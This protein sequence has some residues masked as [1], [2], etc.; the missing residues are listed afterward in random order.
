MGILDRHENQPKKGVSSTYQTRRT[1]SVASVN[2]VASVARRYRDLLRQQEDLDQIIALP[3][4][5]R[6]AYIEAAVN[7]MMAHDG[8]VFSSKF[9]LDLITLIL[10]ETVG[11]GPLEALMRD[12]SV[13][14]ILVNWIGRPDSESEGFARVFVERHGRLFHE[15]GIQFESFDHLKH[16]VDRIVAPLGRRIDESVPMVDAR[17]HDGSRVNVIMRPIAV[18][19]MDVSIRRFRRDP[20]TM[21][22]L[23]TMGLLTTDMADFL[24]ACVIA[25]CNILVV[26]STSTGKTTLLNVLASFIPGSERIV[27][28]EDAAELSFY[29]SHPDVVRTETRRPN[30]EGVGEISACQLVSN[31]L[32]QRPDWIIM[33]EVRGNEALD[34]LQALNTGHAGMSSLH[35]NSPREAFN[36]LAILIRRADG[37]KELPLQAIREQLVGAID[38]IVQIGRMKDGQRRIVSIAEVQGV[39]HEEVVLRELFAFHPNIEIDGSLGGSFTATGAIPRHL[40]RLELHSG[41]LTHLFESTYLQQVLG[42]AILQ[43]EDISEIMV[44]DPQDVWVEERGRLRRATE[45]FFRDRIHLLNII[46]TIIAPLDRRLDELNPMVDAR[47]PDD[48]RFPGGGRINALLDPLAIKGPVLTIRRFSRTRLTLERLVAL[49][50]M[51]HEMARFL[52]ACVRAR[53]NIIISGGAGSGKTSLLGAIASEIDLQHE[54]LIVIE[55]T[56]ELLI[57]RAGDHVVRLETRPAN[58]FGEGRITIS[59]LVINALRMRPDRL[60]IGEV[61]GPEALYMLQ[62]MNTG[63]AGSLTTLHA[64]APEELPDRLETLVLMARETEGLTLAAI[65]RQICTLNIIV[66]QERMEDGSRKVVS[67]AGLAGL[68]ERGQVVVQDVFRFVRQG[69]A[70]TGEVLGEHVRVGPATRT[71]AALRARGVE[72]E[73]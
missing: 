51:T 19:G 34:M 11:L 55:D 28:I 69:N 22:D 36:R 45:V 3:H 21:S 46:N 68:D 32:R 16:I 63:H 41:S 26:G 14:E 24:K 23:I 65:R 44:N 70:A 18:D 48:V 33:G 30:I 2:T 13:S 60:V 56:A 31:A 1:T 37:A 64:N 43:N 67:I 39:S 71:F 59:D 9:R 6:R 5:A 61:R 4:E 54:R 35:A 29:R 20:F 17:L 50:S 7:R 73:V 10:D 53:L 72:L 52:Q 57:G 42:P 66:Q 8:E 47:L 27:T 25:R 40:P 49:G 38:I 12:P 15:V 62:A 58:S